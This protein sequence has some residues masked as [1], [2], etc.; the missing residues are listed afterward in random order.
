MLRII[1]LAGRGALSGERYAG[2]DVERRV[3]R[4]PRFSHEPRTGG[5]RE[6]NR[7]EIATRSLS[8]AT[9]HVIGEHDLS[10]HMRLRDALDLAAARRRNLVVDLSQCAFIDS[11][12]LRLL[13][14]AQGE[15]SSDG[16]RFA[17]VVPA[18][19]G[20]VASMADMI[21]LVGLVPLY[22]SLQAAVADVEVGAGARR[23]QSRIAPEGA[24]HG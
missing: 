1:L 2:R 24:H 4:Y 8:L 21:D 17:V 18:D 10:Q 15:V 23:D 20:P 3:M 12:L 11:M 13:L 14:Y 19:E 22:T 16:G 6:P 7:V 9:V 5:E